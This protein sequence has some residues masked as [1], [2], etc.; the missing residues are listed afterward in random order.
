MVLLLACAPQPT[1]A[2]PGSRSAELASRAGMVARQA[3][4]VGLRAQELEG[5]F[6]Q[7]RATPALEAR[8]AL[9]ADLRARSEEVLEQARRVRDDVTAIEAGAEVF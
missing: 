6:D 8:A 2:A 4:A 3:E 1:S 7:L 9:I 5:I